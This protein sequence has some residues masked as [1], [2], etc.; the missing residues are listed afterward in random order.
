MAVLPPLWQFVIDTVDWG[1]D[2][3]VWR[4]WPGLRA[5]LLPRLRLTCH[6]LTVLLES[7]SLGNDNGRIVLGVVQHIVLMA[8][9]VA[10]S[11]RRHGGSLED[12][13]AP[14]PLMGELAQALVVQPQFLNMVKASTT[15][16]RQHAHLDISDPRPG[17]TVAACL[18]AAIKYAM[19]SL[20]FCMFHW[21]RPSPAI[22]PPPPKL[23]NAM[24]NWSATALEMLK[25]GG[26]D[27]GLGPTDGHLIGYGLGIPLIILARE[28][29]R[30][31]GVG[32]AP[33]PWADRPRCLE[34]A[35]QA[36]E[37]MLSV[38]DRGMGGCEGEID[39]AWTGC[40]D[41]IFLL[42]TGGLTWSYFCL[43]LRQGSLFIEAT[44]NRS[45][46]ASSVTGSVTCTEH[47]EQNWRMLLMLEGWVRRMAGAYQGG[48]NQRIRGSLRNAS[49]WLGEMCSA[50]LLGVQRIRGAAQPS[51]AELRM[52]L[53]AATT[54]SKVSGTTPEAA[55]LFLLH[56]K[57][58]LCP[59]V[60][61]DLTGTAHLEVHLVSLYMACVLGQPGMESRIF[62]VSSLDGP[63]RRSVIAHAVLYLQNIIR[64]WMFRATPAVSMGQHAIALLMTGPL[65]SMLHAALGI[66]LHPFF[67]LSSYSAFGC[68]GRHRP[69]SEALQT[70]LTMSDFVLYGLLLATGQPFPSR[71][72]RS[73]GVHFSDASGP[74]AELTA[75]SGVGSSTSHQGPQLPSSSEQRSMVLACVTATNALLHSDV[76]DRLVELWHMRVLTGQ[77]GTTQSARVNASVSQKPHST[78]SSSLGESADSSDAAGYGWVT[79]GDPLRGLLLNL[80]DVLQRSHSF[81]RLA[82]TVSAGDLPASSADFEHKLSSINFDGLAGS[83]TPSASFFDVPT[84][85]QAET[86]QA[87]LSMLTQLRSLATEL[88]TMSSAVL[89]QPDQQLDASV[90]FEREYVG[91]SWS[92]WEVLQAALLKGLPPEQ[93]EDWGR[94]LGC[95][96]PGCTNLSGPSELQ[97]KTYACGGGC[98]V[99]YCSRECQVQG[100]RLG[101]RHSCGEIPRGKEKRPA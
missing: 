63:P 70:L 80:A 6:S 20:H 90:V 28:V 96:N 42:A 82:S 44:Q 35:L 27:R 16:A 75:S 7:G 77:L 19:E 40:Y 15:W 45:C 37:W 99:R 11:I 1:Y 69:T 54:L 76:L 12:V 94:P 33:L 14:D 64:V 29:E 68:D 23:P 2:V 79:V 84:R 47:L 98:G 101:H 58:L 87:G 65:W 39:D 4:R 73:S 53:S 48:L 25:A 86:T 56:L 30:H 97:L 62:P 3:A 88:L 89:A 43:G 10:P 74:D 38:A 8:A 34:C 13:A 95:C 83:D 21:S 71:G 50:H 67:R 91:T 66:N 18:D 81:I 9:L 59:D 61:A 36:A 85:T 72:G 93:Q 60:G 26:P 92:R 51:G 52:Q 46:F 31:L 41:L 32:I 100:W 22:D 24:L 17:I 5:L 49:S 57:N 55:D 78:D